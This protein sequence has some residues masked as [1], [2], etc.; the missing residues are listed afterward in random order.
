MLAAGLVE[1]VPFFLHLQAQL[2]VG[3]GPRFGSNSSCNSN[4]LLPGLISLQGS[5]F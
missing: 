4:A 5:L 2:F 3:M 1:I